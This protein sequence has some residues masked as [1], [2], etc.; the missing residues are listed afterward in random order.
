MPIS[1]N[2]YILHSAHLLKQEARAIQ[3]DLV[4]PYQFFASLWTSTVARVS[5][6]AQQ[7]R[8]PRGGPFAANYWACV[9]RYLCFNR[10]EIV[11][12]DACL[13]ELVFLDLAARSHRLLIEDT[14]VLRHLVAGMFLR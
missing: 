1:I 2:T 14:Y 4:F 7:A 5:E 3:E 8:L 6:K 11:A 9:S 13:A 12:L 10:F